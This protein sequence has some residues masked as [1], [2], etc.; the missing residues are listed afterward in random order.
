MQ[1]LIVADSFKESLNAE[2]VAQAIAA[3][4]NKIQPQLTSHCI[5]LTVEKVL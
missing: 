1:V 4:V 5:L 2:Q 3:G